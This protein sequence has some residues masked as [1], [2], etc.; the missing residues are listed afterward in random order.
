MFCKLSWFDNGFAIKSKYYRTCLR[1]VLTCISS[2]K[3]L[4]FG[5]CFILYFLKLSAGYG[6]SFYKIEDLTYDQESCFDEKTFW[7]RCNLSW[8]NP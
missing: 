2:F 8:E 4:I 6:F 3:M 5:L 1:L 7:L